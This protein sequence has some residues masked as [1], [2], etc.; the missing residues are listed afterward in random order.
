MPEMEKVILN[1]I[2]NPG[3]NETECWVWNEVQANGE[4]NLGKYCEEQKKLSEPEAL[5]P[6]KGEDSRWSDPSGR[7]QRPSSNGY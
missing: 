7:S 5:D 4:A 6:H 2:K 1:S 3:D